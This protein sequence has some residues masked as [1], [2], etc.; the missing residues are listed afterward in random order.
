MYLWQI[1]PRAR[2]VMRALTLF[3]PRHRNMRIH[4]SSPSGAASKKLET[5]CD[6]YTSSY[7]WPDVPLG[8]YRN[9]IRSEN[10]EQMTFDDAIFDL[11]I[12]QDVFEHVLN[13]GKAFAE[14]ARVLKPG[15]AHIFTVPYSKSTKTLV[16]AVQT[17]EG[18]KYLTEKRYHGNPID[19]QGA[20]VVTDWGYDLTDFIYLNSG[21]TTTIYGIT[22]PGLGLEAESLEVFVSR[23]AI[24]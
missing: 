1:C 11:V 20:L 24:S 10:L 19:P 5:E 4:E 3:F 15:G 8:S 23:K 14:V 6:N 21:I 13:P 2:A 16:R 9:G 22:D 7:F 18:I 17:T 12:T